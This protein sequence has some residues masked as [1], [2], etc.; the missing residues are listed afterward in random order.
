[1]TFCFEPYFRILEIVYQ[2]QAWV[3]RSGWAR[4]ALSVVGRE[5]I[6]FGGSGDFTKRHRKILEANASEQRV[7][8]SP[9]RTQ[10]SKGCTAL[11]KPTTEILSGTL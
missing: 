6:G 8:H 11:S 5:P 7:G 9:K 2:R 1:M 10:V 3:G 4:P